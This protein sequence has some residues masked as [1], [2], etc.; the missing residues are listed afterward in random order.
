MTSVRNIVTSVAGTEAGPYTYEIGPKVSS[1]TTVDLLAPFT[2]RTPDASGDQLRE[3]ISYDEVDP[4]RLFPVAG[5]VS[6]RGV[7]AGDKVGIGVRDIGCAAEGHIW[8][9]PGLGFGNPGWFAVRKLAIRPP[10]VLDATGIS[11]PYAPHI[12]ALGVLPPGPLPARTLGEYGGNLDVPELGPGAM[13]WVTA[14]IDGGGVFAG[15]VHAAIGDAEVCG[16]GVET[17]AEVDL[18]VTRADFEWTSPN[19]VVMT[20][21]RIWVI[22]IGPTL[23]EAL[24][25]VLPVVTAA[26]GENLK[27]EE[28]QAYLLTSVLLDVRPCQVVNPLMS[29]AV[30][31]R[32][33]LDRWLVP[34]EAHHVFTQFSETNLKEIKGRQ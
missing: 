16:T 15:D 20:P 34:P 17:A 7:L 26:I 13:L 32:H 30:S 28:D 27:I 2:L 19:P 33:G 18:V 31:L 12:G 14:A 24:I 10:V 22:G 21:D 9:R 29:V 6:V 5:P 3:G 1:V 4:S 11:L 25:D 8:T 23:E